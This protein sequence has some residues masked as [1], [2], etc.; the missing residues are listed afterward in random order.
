[1]VSHIHIQI[2]KEDMFVATVPYTHTD[3]QW[4]LMRTHPHTHT[5]TH[6]RAQHTYTNI[7]RGH[8]SNYSFL[9]THNTQWVLMC[10]HTHTHTHAH[11][12]ITH[13]SKYQK[14]TCL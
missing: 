2:S 6:T 1:M 12:R 7:K 13:I 8:V 4:V 14:R 3:T 5:Q 9:H 10:T 11:V